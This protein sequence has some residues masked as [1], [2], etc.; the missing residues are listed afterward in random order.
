MKHRPSLPLPLRIAGPALIVLLLGFVLLPVIV[1]TIASFNEKALL[2]FPPQSWSLK[3]FERALTYP[4]FQGGF[5]ASII[6]TL[7][8]STIALVIGTGM[9]IAIKRFEFPG[10]ET[11]EAILLSPLVIPHFTL[12]LGLLILVSQ[13]GAGRGYG[14]LIAC[15]VML[16]LP[17]V[18]RSVWGLA[19]CGHHVLQRVHG[20]A[21][22]HHASNADPARGDVQ[23]RARVCRPDA[24]GALRALHL[25]DRFRADHRQLLPG[26]GEDPQ[27]R[28]RALS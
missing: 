20:I 25:H 17:F 21:V 5:R 12:G 4:D 1:V 23:L 15:H 26:S 9:A 2:S 10:K 27:H 28:G 7:W 8:S 13:L 24:C 3:W 14:L 11:L 16:V 19:L 22:R 18:L 6:A